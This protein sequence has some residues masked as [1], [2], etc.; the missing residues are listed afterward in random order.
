M[1]KVNKT[2]ADQDHGK[3]QEGEQE[4]EWRVQAEAEKNEGNLMF[5]EGRLKECIEAY[6]RAIALDVDNHVLY[7]NRS[8]AYLKKGDAKSKALKDAEKCVALKPDWTKGYSRLGAAQ[9][10][11]G[12]YGAALASFEK[13]LAIDKDNVTLAAA[14]EAC[15]G[16][17]AAWLKQKQEAAKREE[18]AA[19]AATAVKSSA[20]PLS[21]FF[22]ELGQTEEKVKV[23]EAVK[24]KQSRET[25]KYAEQDLGTSTAQ[26]H[27]LT[28]G[29]HQWRNLNPFLVLDLGID[30]TEDDIKQRYRKLSAL[31]HP[32]KLQ[33]AG[34]ETSDPKLAFG[35]VKSAHLQLLDKQ[36]RSNIV[37]NI[38]T[39]KR[40][41]L[42][43]KGKYSSEDEVEAEIYKATMKRFADIELQRR[44]TEEVLRVNQQRE[45][46]SMEEEKRREKEELK[47]NKDFHHDDEAREKRINNW[48]DFA[49][50]TK[51]A[52]HS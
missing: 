45:K 39:A 28:E 8:A 9:Q 44:R 36:K 13:G 42:D 22:N 31:L 17:E 11:L 47:R 6:S 23:V 50:G 24:Q 19:A 41:V 46:A 25:Q 34:L 3:E 14:L 48:R 4:E 10:S 32:D 26:Y 29:S 49:P 43:G 2:M 5:K 52:K 51:K 40:D 37:A 33:Q 15:R 16:A 1:V 38:E 7:S 35:Y 20:D 12:R 27:R 30:A 21:D 18:A